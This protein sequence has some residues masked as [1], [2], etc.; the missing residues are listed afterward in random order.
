MGTCLVENM[1]WCLEEGSDVEQS[2]LGCLRQTS[3]ITK[4]VKGIRILN[5]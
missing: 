2:Q 5:T 4:V 1:N 3:Q